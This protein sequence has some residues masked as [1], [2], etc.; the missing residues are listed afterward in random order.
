MDRCTLICSSK[1]LK[2]HENKQNDFLPYEIAELELYNIQNCR[3]FG[4][5]PSSNILET[6]ILVFRIPDDGQSPKIQ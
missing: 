4:L 3:V 2:C 5:S 6:I 1:F